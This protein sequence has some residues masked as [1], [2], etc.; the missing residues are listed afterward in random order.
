VFRL[1]WPQVELT[2]N[3]ISAARAA[4]SGSVAPT[5]LNGIVSATTSQGAPGYNVEGAASLTQSWDDT[6]T[7]GGPA[8][9]TPVD[10]LITFTFHTAVKLTD[11]LSGT[12]YNQPYAS[13]DLRQTVRVSAGC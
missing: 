11:V 4:N 3:D 13:S 12:L 7:V 9:G 8:N 10:I 1:R 6:L 2:T 5:R